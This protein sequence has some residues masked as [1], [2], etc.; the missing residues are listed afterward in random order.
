MASIEDADVQPIADDQKPTDSEQPSS[1]T[2]PPGSSVPATMA[3]DERE[4]P[5][6]SDSK[7]QVEIPQPLSATPSP[8]SLVPPMDSNASTAAQPIVSDNEKL[9]NTLQE[10]F[11]NLLKEQKEQADRMCQGIEELKPKPLPTTDKKTEFWKAYKTIADEYDKDY[12]EKYTTDL[13]S[14]LIFAGLFLS[15]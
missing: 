11:T 3:A 13:D 10:C 8:G 5:P 9:I 2:P 15:R 12:R 6:I 1:A 7:R 14:S 4:T